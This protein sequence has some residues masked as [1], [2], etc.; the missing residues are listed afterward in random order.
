MGEVKGLTSSTTAISGAS[1]ILNASTGLVGEII[2]GISSTGQA[3]V[4]ISL[5]GFVSASSFAIASVLKIPIGFY[6]SLINQITAHFQD[7]ADINNLTVRY[8]NDPRSTPTDGLWCNCNIDFGNAEQSELG[9]TSFRHIGNF[10]IR[11]KN[12]IGLGTN[13]LLQTADIIVTAFRTTDLNRIIFNVPRIRN[14]GRIDDNHQVN[15][16]CPFFSDKVS[17]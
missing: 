7:I 9:I 4:A 17:R 11:I 14:V 16:I 12:P 3:T 5:Y 6:E 15:V 8:E 13:E 2:A 1:G 10:V